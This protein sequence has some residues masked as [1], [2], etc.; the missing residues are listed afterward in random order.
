MMGIPKI[1][2]FK[3]FWYELT[4]GLIKLEISLST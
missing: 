3:L 4:R 1:E 2:F